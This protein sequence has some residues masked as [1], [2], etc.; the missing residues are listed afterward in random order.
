ME[1]SI[2]I[3]D[4]SI[5]GA[6]LTQANDTEL[7]ICNSFAHSLF[8]EIICELCSVPISDHSRHYGTKAFILQ[9]FSLSRNIKLNNLNTEYWIHDDITDETTVNSKCTGF[10][11][12]GKIVRRS[13][14]I[15]VVFTPLLDFSALQQHL[16]PGHNLRL[17]FERS[18]DSFPLL[19]TNDN[20]RPKVRIHNIYSTIRC[21]IP[22]SRYLG[23]LQQKMSSKGVPYLLTRNVIRNY[24]MGQGVTNVSVANIFR[25]NLPRA[26]YIYFLNNEQVNGSYKHNP[27]IFKHYSI[28]EAS[29]IMNGV[30]YPSAPIKIDHKK[31]FVMEAYRKMLDNIGLPN[32]D[33]S[34]DVNAFAYSSSSFILAFDL[35][36]TGDNGYVREK[37]RQGTL[38]FN[39]I[40]DEPLPH[41]VT[42]ICHAIF[43][44][45]VS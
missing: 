40:L 1:L 14:I 35:S 7:S 5:D 9:N 27:H 6:P 19:C 39:G 11:E 24:V 8:N 38:S 26:L 18:R 4:N 10:V 2:V 12:R 32:D 15:Q 13:K 29:V 42:L 3:D 28:R 31:G 36:S 17:K 45:T 34:C 21:A 30:Q 43:E 22:T 33:Q 16:A 23:Q 37:P 41:S 44:D 25:G 20:L